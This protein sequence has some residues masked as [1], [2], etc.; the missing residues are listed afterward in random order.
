GSCCA[1]TGIRCRTWTRLPG[2]CWPAACRHS[3]AMTSPEPAAPPA[4]DARAMSKPE[5]MRLQGHR[6]ERDASGTTL[7]GY[8]DGV[9]LYF[10][11]DAGRDLMPGPE[12]FLC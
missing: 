12:P 10:K 7:S 3:A 5:P 9:E 8:V 1:P 6:L 2:P 4:E 11:A